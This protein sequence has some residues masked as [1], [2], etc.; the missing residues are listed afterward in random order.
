M[1]DF[2]LSQRSPAPSPTAPSDK[3]VIFD[4]RPSPNSLILRSEGDLLPVGYICCQGRPALE[5][6]REA[7]IGGEAPPVWQL[8]CLL[9]QQT[10]GCRRCEI[11]HEARR[12]V[13]VL[14]SGEDGELTPAHF[15]EP[16]GMVVRPLFAR[17]GSAV[18]ESRTLA[19]LRNAAEV[20]FRGAA[21][22]GS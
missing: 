7:R 9:D 21:P 17:T 2:L 12:R 15:T 22:Q 4:D 19:T 16:F 1:T 6:S 13:G 8:A 3:I 10:I 11:R 20:D 14:R 5:R 18:R